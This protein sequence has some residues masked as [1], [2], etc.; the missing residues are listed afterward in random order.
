M[1]HVQLAVVAL[2]ALREFVSVRGFNEL[3]RQHNRGLPPSWYLCQADSLGRFGC[4]L[5]CSRGLGMLSLSRP[6][7]E[8]SENRPNPLVA[9]I[10][11][12]TLVPVLK[13]ID[14]G[15][16]DRGCDDL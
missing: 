4:S 11:M 2:A 5:R 13:N 8:C 9:W 12:K 7:E 15:Q 10:A 16:F 14:P 6:S 1:Q 3:R